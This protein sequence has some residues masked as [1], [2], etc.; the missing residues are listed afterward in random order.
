[1]LLNYQYRAYPESSQK[2]QLNEWKRICQYWYNWQ[3]GDRLNWWEQNR[4]YVIL[5]QGEFCYISCSLPPLEL[6]DK[7]DYCNQKKLLPE[8]KKDFV[9]VE[10]SGELLDFTKV[11]SQTLQDVSKRVDLAF[12]RFIKGDKNGKKSGKP[13]FKS[14]SSFRT[15]RIEG[16]AV[17]I[18]RIEK[19]WLFLSISKLPGWL[20]VRLHRPLPDGFTLKNILLTKKADGWY[21]TI[22]L[23]DP[24]VPVFNPDEII[25]TWEN[26]MGMD[27]VLHEDDY[28]ATSCGSKLPSLKSFRKSQDRLAK[29]SK[30]KS[31]KKKGSARRRKLAKREAREHQRIARSRKDHAYKTAHKLVR[32]GKKVFFHEDL[33]L[34]GL[35]KRN[36]AKKD[37]NGTFIPNKQSAK[38]GLNKSWNDA[39][40]GQFFTTLDYIASKAGAKVMGVNPAYTSM[41]LAY[42]DEIVFTDCSIRN[43]FDREERFNVDRDINAAIN[44]K[45]VGLGLFPTI[46]SRRGKVVITTTATASTSK[47]VLVVLKNARSGHLQSREVSVVHE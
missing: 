38:S 22:A 19:D 16:Q 14:A 23:E 26:S 35:T 40:F 25:P 7:P 33:N 12:S 21:V 30:R 1:M 34:R 37:E 3:L 28:L 20:K 15:L 43:Y 8:L 2:E 44:I 45:R 39:A 27:A 46:K 9:Q 47:E 32:T 4:D 10:Y 6:R 42:R 18:E 41:L 24:T 17:T 11:P 5:P 36:K 29:V 13:R 31:T